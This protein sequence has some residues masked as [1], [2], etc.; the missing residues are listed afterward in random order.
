[1]TSDH[2][3]PRIMFE[4]G[5]K[6]FPEGAFG[7]VAYV[8]VSGE[9][10]IAR[11]VKGARKVLGTIRNGGVFGEMALIDGKPRMAEAVALSQTVC[12]VIKREIFDNKIKAA[13]PFVKGLLRVLVQNV[14]SAADR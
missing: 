5:Q 1:M 4:E 14:R 7:D 3:M 12:Q 11:T 10:E 9:V 8:V 6:I 2:M 13:D